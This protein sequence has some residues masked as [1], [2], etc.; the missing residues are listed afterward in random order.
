MAKR[1]L[2]AVAAVAAV[3]L[4]GAGGDALGWPWL[5]LV[6]LFLLLVRADLRAVMVSN[7]LAVTIFLVLAAVVAAATFGTGS[8]LFGS[9]WFAGLGGVLAVNCLLCI[10]TRLNRERTFWSALFHGAVL[11]VLAGGLVK[12]SFKE[13][14]EVNLHVGEIATT[15]AVTQGDGTVVEEP[16]PFPLRL[17]DFEIEFYES[18]RQVLLYDLAA[19]HEQPAATL[20]LTEGAAVAVG[21]RLV[22]FVGERSRSFAPMPD[23]PEVTVREVVIDCAGEEVALTMAGRG[24]RSGDV[25]L[26][27]GQ[28]QGKP[29]RFQSRLAV[30]DER[31]REVVGKEVVVNDPLIH[32]GWWLYQANWGEAEGGR[33]SGIRVVRDPGLP[34]VL[35]G[36]ALLLLGMAA[37]L[38]LPGRRARP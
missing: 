21:E 12:G 28:E 9:C 31:G 23:H 17:D 26:V 16:L 22:R 30:L 37:E 1:Y 32:D 29:R 18:Q 27:L 20:P 35:G 4:A 36:L 7:E 33:Y 2:M 3:A 25:G 11:L 14:G 24:M 8:G 15:M 5:V 10:I 38:L 13:E 19:N 6:P 34:L